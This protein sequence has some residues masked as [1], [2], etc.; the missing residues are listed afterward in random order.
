MTIVEMM[1]RSSGNT[2]LKKVWTWVQPSMYAASSRAM[3]IFPLMNPWNMNTDM[4]ME[5]PVCRKIRVIL[6]FSTFSIPP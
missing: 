6:W 4:A 1:G 2:I 3:G 5:N